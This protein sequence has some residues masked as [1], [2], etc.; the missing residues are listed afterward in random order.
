MSAC[1]SGRGR[2]VNSP[3]TKSSFSVRRG[4]CDD[5]DDCGEFAVHGGD[6][7]KSQ[8]RLG[9]KDSEFDRKYSLNELVSGDAVFSAT[10]VTDGALLEGVK[11]VDG[12]VLTHTLVMT[13]ATGEVRTVRTK[14]KA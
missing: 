5:D 8:R 7:G 4:V 3:L 6:Q 10:G 12:Y 13:S 14:R 11:L 9:L 2:Q 1:D